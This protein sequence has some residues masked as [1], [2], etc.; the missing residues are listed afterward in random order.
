MESLALTGIINAALNGA[1]DMLAHC[2][3]WQT[4]C[5]IDAGDAAAKALAAAKRIQVYAQKP[6]EE[7]VFENEELE[8]RRPLAVIWRAD[9][10]FS[11]SRVASGPT[12]QNGGSLLI[13]IEANTPTQWQESESLARIWFTNQVGAVYAGL[14]A[15]TDAEAYLRVTAHGIA[16]DAKRERN[17]R[18]P[19]QGDYMAMTLRLA[20]GGG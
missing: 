18:R 20:W 10:G 11:G 2:A 19:S 15:M 3:A 16:E 14:L 7:T 5:G 17:S 4:F 8:L 6:P 12:W 9:G 13:R 1:A